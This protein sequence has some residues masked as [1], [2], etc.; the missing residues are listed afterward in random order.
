MKERL[1]TTVQQLKPSGIRRFFDLAA[2]MDNVISLGVGEPDF[3]TSWAV[4]EASIL[5]LERGYTSYTA[6]AGLLELRF[7][8]MKYMKRNFNVSY[9]YKDDIIV[10][11]G[12]SQALD[13][14]MRALIN[15]EDEIIVVEPNF[16]SYS[17]LISLAGGVPVAIE[18][19]AETEFK[20][21][22]RQIEE[23]ITSNTKA[24]LLCSPNNPT[25]SSLS[26]EELQAIADIVIKHDLL[27][28]T[29]E[30]YAELTYD[31][32]F[33]S[34]ASL[35][36]M[37]ERT[38]IISGFSKGFA[39][40]GWRLGYI[41]APTEIAKAM[42]KIHQ[43]TMMCAPTMAQ[44]GAIEALQNGQHD[45][46]EMRKSYRRRRNY[47]VKSLNQIGLECHSPGGAFYVFPSVKKTGLSSEEFAEQ[48]LLEERV[49][50]VPGNV[51]GKGG[52]GHIRCSYA[53]SMESLEESIKRI[54]RFVENKL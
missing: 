34:I 26:K 5:S 28:I 6:N 20:L 14:T 35:E 38:I 50:V 18:T 49:A 10:T 48:L 31:E 46:E 7:E 11:V 42:L 24:L 39:M 54:S 37:K 4:R 51:F 52:E 8:I 21:Q 16:V 44:Y 40:T 36:G 29:D 53:S 33:T 45:V 19:T 25:G 30:I 41:C 1:S 23:V 43:Y 17:P 13:I 9:D 3:V 2:S 15:P 47:M 27:V 32:E 12:G 22:P